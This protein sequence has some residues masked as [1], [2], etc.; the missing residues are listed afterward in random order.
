M[1]LT[2]LDCAQTR[3]LQ[4]WLGMV[5]SGTCLNLAITGLQGALIHAAAITTHHW[6][7]HQI[8]ASH[9]SRPTPQEGTRRP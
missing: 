1:D 5:E 9:P 3:P 2:K 7:G 8:R 4:S 6:I